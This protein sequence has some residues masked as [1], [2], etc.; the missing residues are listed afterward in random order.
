[1]N[2]ETIEGD[3]TTL[4]VKGSWFL[5]DRTEATRRITYVRYSCESYF[6]RDFP[7]QA[8]IFRQVG[9]ANVKALIRQL[10][11]AAA[12]RASTDQESANASSR[13]GGRP[14]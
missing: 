8:A 9:A 5:E 12:R 7:A 11:E 6:A 13:P 10:G 1:M 14:R 2:F 3:A 4:S